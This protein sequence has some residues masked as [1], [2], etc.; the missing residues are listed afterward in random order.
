MIRFAYFRSNVRNNSLEIK[1]LMNSRFLK[2]KR[3]GSLEIT[4]QM[5]A[6]MSIELNELDVNS[7]INLGQTSVSVGKSNLLG[8]NSTNS[9]LPLSE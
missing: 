6:S 3:D 9:I 8:R 7:S 1:P 4:T 2:K 5:K